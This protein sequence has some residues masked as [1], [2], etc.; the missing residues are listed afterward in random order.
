M[1]IKYRQF[2]NNSYLE[3]YK[4][5]ICNKNKIYFLFLCKLSRNKQDRYLVLANLNEWHIQFSLQL[6]GD[7]YRFFYK[8]NT[9]SDESIVTQKI[10][11]IVIHLILIVRL[12]FCANSIEWNFENNLKSK[13][14]FLAP[15]KFNVWLL[16]RCLQ[17]I[18]N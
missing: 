10:K 4:M 3:R 2:S 5:Y 18:S 7:I 14:L 16:Q 17:E 15:K 11:S 1:D 9:F 8:Y 6:R 12:R 13:K